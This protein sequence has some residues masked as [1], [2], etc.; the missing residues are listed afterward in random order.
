MIFSR[1]RY[2]GTLLGAMALHNVVQSV[3]ELFQWTVTILSFRPVTSLITKCN[4]PTRLSAGPRLC[5]EREYGKRSKERVRS[6]QRQSAAT[7]SPAESILT[8]RY[9]PKCFRMNTYEKTRGGAPFCPQRSFRHF[10]NHSCT[11]KSC[12]C[13]SYESTRGWPH[14]SPPNVHYTAH[15]PRPVAGNFSS[16]PAS[17]ARIQTAIHC[18]LKQEPTQEGKT[19]D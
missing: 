10:R 18:S 19:N 1:P 13:H 3:P 7:V 9:V 5:R 6:G 11:R 12:I 17:H 15:P 4:R 2:H 14:S 16:S 8:N